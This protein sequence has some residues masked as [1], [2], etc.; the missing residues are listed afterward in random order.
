MASQIRMW[1]DH[2]GRDVA[3]QLIKTETQMLYGYNLLDIRYV[4]AENLPQAGGCQMFIRAKKLSNLDAALVHGLPKERGDDD[5]V[6]GVDPIYVMVRPYPDIRP[7]A[8]LEP[9]M[10]H[11]LS[12][13][14][15]TRNVIVGHG[16]DG[17]YDA[18]VE[19]YGKWR[20]GLELPLS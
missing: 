13:I 2:E 14:N 12:H 1:V 17:G 5:D 7:E 11:G 6:M 18:E 10:F 19:R 8:G 16:R 9:I 15:V 20:A 3:N 4:M